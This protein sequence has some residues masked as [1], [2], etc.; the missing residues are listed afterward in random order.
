[1]Q[2][3]Q[4][5][6]DDIF[7]GPDW[8]E[9]EDGKFWFHPSSTGKEDDE[10]ETEEQNPLP[11]WRGQDSMSAG[12]GGMAT[13]ATSIVPCATGSSSSS[14]HCADAAAAAATDPWSKRKSLLAKSMVA[15]AIRRYNIDGQC[16]PAKA[17]SLKVNDST[18][19][20]PITI[21]GIGVVVLCALALHT[22]GI[23]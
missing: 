23:F 19:I 15:R 18:M 1:M 16:Q 20:Q 21:V 11:W 3:D 7:H 13:C 8:T 2:L 4:A 17:I 5:E 10:P 6:L 12:A 22:R 9:D 14:P